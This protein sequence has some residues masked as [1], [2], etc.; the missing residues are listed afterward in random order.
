MLQMDAAFQPGPLNEI[1][2]IMKVLFLLTLSPHVYTSFFSLL[3][4]ISP[5][6]TAKKLETIYVLAQR[7]QSALEK[8]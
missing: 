7:K 5:L 3:P 8:S 1:R 6:D 2:E 4:Q